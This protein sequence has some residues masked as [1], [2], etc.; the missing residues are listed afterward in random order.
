MLSYEDLAAAFRKNKVCT[1]NRKEHLQLIFQLIE[2]AHAD[3]NF[4]WTSAALHE[5]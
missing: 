5:E 4:V 1:T 2:N 3:I